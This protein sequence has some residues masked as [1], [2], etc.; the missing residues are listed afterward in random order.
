MKKPNIN[1]ILV[2]GGGLALEIYSYICDE[3]E[4]NNLSN[5]L[6]KG[7]LDS[8]PDCELCKKNPEVKYLG[9]IPAYKTEENDFGIITVGSATTRKAICSVLLKISLPLFTYIHSTAYIALNANIGNGVF[10][11]PH[12]FVSA[13]SLIADNVVMNIFCGV[14]HSTKIGK[15]SVMSPCSNI[16]GDCEL[17]ESVFL[18]SGVVVNPKTI[19]GDF[20]LID[21]GSTIRESI[22][23]LSVVSQ[24][25]EQKIYDNRILKKKLIDK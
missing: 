3:Q 24:R 14:G 12:S 16:N 10:I 20:S 19:I 21:A 17:G 8:S 7:V 6:I 15:H 9:D 23:S 5:I 22:P 1:L 11:G 13:H 2:G 25:V 4:R 18:G